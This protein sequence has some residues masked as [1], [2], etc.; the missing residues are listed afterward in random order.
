MISALVEDRKYVESVLDAEVVSRYPFSRNIIVHPS[1]QPRI[2]LLSDIRKESIYFF[3]D[4]NYEGHES[5]TF[6]AELNDTHLY[7]LCFS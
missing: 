2:T 1:V 6:L 7:G 5:R 3:I 4:P